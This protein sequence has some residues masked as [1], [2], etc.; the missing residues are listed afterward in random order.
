MK[1]PK[2]TAFTLIELL[3]VVLIIGILAAIALPQYQKAVLK[4]RTAQLYTFARYFR[5]L[6]ALQQMAAG[7]CSLP[8]TD[9]GWGYEIENYRTYETQTGE[10][11][12]SFSSAG[13]NVQH[14]DNNFTVYLRNYNGLY[15][16]VSYPKIFCHAL[17]SDS[18]AVGV[19]QNLGGKYRTTISS[20]G[21]EIEQYE[22]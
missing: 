9:M 15:F 10:T 8:L 1:N 2:S 7:S 22:L 18:V 13:Y 12:E 21:L 16:H 6:C 3:V 4:S 20:N 14:A 5:D 11:G 17:A 19:C